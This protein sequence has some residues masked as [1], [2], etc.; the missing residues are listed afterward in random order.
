[1]PLYFEKAR[2]LGGLLLE[3]PEN[4][5]LERA[6]AEFE[7]NAEASAAFESLKQRRAELQKRINSGTVTREKYNEAVKGLTEL[8]LELKKHP[9][10]AEFSAAET[11]FYGLVSQTLETVK[12]TVTGELPEG[13]ACGGSCGG[14][15]GCD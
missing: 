14:C 10:I 7:K 2:E 6:R 11:E 12:S 9:L 1:M 8:T 15:R 4:K 5:R 13:S 3:T